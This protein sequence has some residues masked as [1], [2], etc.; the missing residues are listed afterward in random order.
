MHGGC[1]AKRYLGEGIVVTFVKGFHDIK[2]HIVVRHPD[3]SCVVKIAGLTSLW[4]E[5]ERGKNRLRKAFKRQKRN[6]EKWGANVCVYTYACVSCQSFYHFPENRFRQ[7]WVEHI[8]E[9]PITVV[10]KKDIGL[11]IIMNHGERMKELTWEERGW[12]LW[13]IL[14][15]VYSSAVFK[16]FVTFAKHLWHVVGNVDTRVACL[17]IIVFLWNTK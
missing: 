6:V 14:N 11:S 4:S 15:L 3:H 5:G 16:A 7:I 10:E 17:F 12:N 9:I 2:S 1:D 13:L 8:I